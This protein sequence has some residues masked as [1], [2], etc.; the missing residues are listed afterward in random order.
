MK[1]SH[2]TIKIKAKAAGGLLKGN[3]TELVTRLLDP[4][5]HQKS[6]RASTVKKS[7]RAS[8]VKNSKPTDQPAVRPMGVIHKPDAMVRNAWDRR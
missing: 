7:R 8:T 5:S 3:K 4:A 6:R 1:M 2:A